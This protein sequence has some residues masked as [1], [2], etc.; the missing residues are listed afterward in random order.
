MNAIEEHCF[1]VQQLNI[2]VIKEICLII[3]QA[4]LNGNKIL[5]MG[6]GGSA[7]D[8]QHLAAEFVGRFKKERRGLPAVALTTD[9]SVIT[10]IANDYGYDSIFER[11]LESLMVPGDVVVGITTSGNSANVIRGLKY[12]RAQG[13][14]TIA[15][16][17]DTGG[18]AINNVDIC[19]TVPS[20]NTARIQ[21]CHILVGHIICEG[22]DGAFD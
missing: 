5:L 14:K 19:L 18:D 2:E 3:K 11:Q 13:A 6:N 1:V 22:I 17:G 21:E 15:F 12:A 20:K 9:S 4:L 7:A 8:C 16:T 10:A